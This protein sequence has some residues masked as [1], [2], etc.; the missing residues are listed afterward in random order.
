MPHHTHV[1]V[2]RAGD[3]LNAFFAAHVA[4]SRRRAVPVVGDDDRYTGMVLLDDVLAVEPVAWPTTA[5]AEVMR[6]D[7]PV[8]RPDWTIGEALF[9]YF[10]VRDVA[11]GVATIASTRPGGNVVKSL[12]LQGVADTVDGAVVGGLVASGRL[13]QAQGIGAV[14]LAAGTAVMEYAAAWQLRRRRQS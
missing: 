2:A 5:V 8:G 14:A 9:R 10:A 3:S 6:V 12:T 11:L 1:A 13:R 7:I 4:V